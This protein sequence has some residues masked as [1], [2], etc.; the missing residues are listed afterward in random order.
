MDFIDGLPLSF[1]KSVIFV[2]VDRLSKAAQF[3][4]LAH[5]YSAASVAQCFLDHVFKL[6]GFP[7]SITSDR[8]VVFLSD[9]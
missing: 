6:H 1:G 7:K 2:V 5:P 4:A 8:D 3:M 9:F